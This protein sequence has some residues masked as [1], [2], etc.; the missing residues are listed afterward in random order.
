MRK[1]AEKCAEEQLGESTAEQRTRLDDGSVTA[2]RMK[3]PNLVSF[4]LGADF[5]REE[6]VL[7][8]LHSEYVNS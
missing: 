8:M 2:A 1:T 4:R 3:Y 6:L 5:D 7:I